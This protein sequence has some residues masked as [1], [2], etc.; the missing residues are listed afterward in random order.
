MIFT[1]M[2]DYIATLETGY[3]ITC[4]SYDS[5][6]DRIVFTFDDEIQFGYLD[7]ESIKPLLK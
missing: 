6:A 4:I 7:L 3:R 1:K 2:G 5:E